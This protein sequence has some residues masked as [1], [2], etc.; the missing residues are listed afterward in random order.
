MERA[1][2][3]RAPRVRMTVAIS[4]AAS[5]TMRLVRHGGDAVGD[6]AAALF[7]L[8]N[9]LIGV[10]GVADEC[11]AAPCAYLPGAYITRPIDYHESF[12][13]YATATDTRIKC[14]S[15]VALRLRIDYT[16]S[17]HDALPI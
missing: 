9:G 3:E 4:S 16:L 15:P 12:P 13:G 1:P 14:P 8:A 11:A 17:L 5:D 10:E 7:A 2:A 6:Q